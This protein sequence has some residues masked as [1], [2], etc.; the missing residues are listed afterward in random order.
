[1]WKSSGRDAGT[2]SYFKT[3]LNLSNVDGNVKHNYA[4]REALLLLVGEFM[5]MEQVMEYLKMDNYDSHPSC[6]PTNINSVSREMK[7]GLADQILMGILNHYQYATFS[8]DSSVLCK[9]NP[10]LKPPTV[11]QVVG[12]TEEGNILVV[13]KVPKVDEVMSHANN[14]SLWAMHLM[15]LNDMAQ[16]GDLDRTILA[17]KLNIPFFFSHSNLSKYFVESIDFL[18]KCKHISSPQMSL[19]VLEGS[20]V[21][22]HGG[23]GKCIETDLLM[24]HSIRN[25]KDLIREL[26]SN[27]KEAAIVRATSAA[28]TVSRVTQNFSNTLGTRIKSNRHTRII[29]EEDTGK[30]KVV[31]RKLRPFKYT[32]ARRYQSMPSCPPLP[33]ANIDLDDMK[34]SMRR[35]I[36]RLCRGQTVQVADPEIV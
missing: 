7:K 9:S 5:I 23:K 26:G 4:A 33:F 31:L 28:E 21:N 19:R 29:S 16:E 22:M 25:K 36:D 14:L 20:F 34:K 6:I 2:L 3:L 17:C 13:D 18:L 32:S 10:I 1:M 35:T 12:T 8:L 27:K 11:F 24:E 15:H 30:V